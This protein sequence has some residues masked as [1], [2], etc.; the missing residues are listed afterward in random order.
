MHHALCIFCAYNVS[1]IIFALWCMHHWVSIMTN[2]SCHMHHFILRME[3]HIMALRIAIIHLK[4][5]SL[6]WLSGMCT[7]SWNI[8]SLFLGIVA[9]QWH[10]EACFTVSIVPL[11]QVI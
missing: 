9:L 6:A 1:I 10:K 7:M 2:A 5:A 4:S 8:L 11:I 3:H